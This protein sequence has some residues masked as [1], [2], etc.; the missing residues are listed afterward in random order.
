MNQTLLNRTEFKESVFKRDNHKCVICGKPAVDAHHIIDRSLF[1]DGGY[2][3]DNGVSL[4]FEHHMLAEETEI[5]CE[6]LRSHAKIKN[7]LYPSDLSLNEFVMDYDK[8]GNPILKDGRRLKGYIFRNANVQKIIQ[9]RLKDFDKPYDPIVDK[10]PRTYHFPFSPGTT[11]DDRIAKNTNILY[12]RPVIITE[13]LDGENCLD[14]DTL[15]ITEFDGKKTIKW[16]CENE[17]KGRVLTYN[18]NTELEEFQY[19]MNWSILDNIGDWYEL[20][21]E[22]GKTLILTGNHRVWLVDLQ[23][24]RKVNDLKEGDDFLL[25]R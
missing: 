24:Y 7:I 20:E 11:S 16:L 13:K 5:S 12:K 22:D 6:F 2:Y 8:W 15:I 18:V 1:D 3:L 4:C 14:A 17:Y 9:S 10:Y 19:V 21:L 25:K 23:C